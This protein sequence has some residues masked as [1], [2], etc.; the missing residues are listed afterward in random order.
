MQEESHS[1]VVQMD[2]RKGR[3]DTLARLNPKIL[4]LYQMAAADS[5]HSRLRVAANE[6]ASIAMEV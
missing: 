6:C 4:H 5:L 1:D 2:H 3:S